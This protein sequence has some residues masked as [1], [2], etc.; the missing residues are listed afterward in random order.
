[1]L[2]IP[3]PLPIAIINQQVQAALAEDQA[4]N[5]VTV[6]AVIDPQLAITLQLRAREAVVVAGLALAEA[7]FRTLSLQIDWQ[8]AVQDGEQVAAGSLLATVSGLASALLSA[9]RTAL[10]CAASVGHCDPDQ[11]LC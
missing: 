1:M 11:A 3:P 5:D 8:Q 10:N 4:A 6:A 2:S 9:E 7:S